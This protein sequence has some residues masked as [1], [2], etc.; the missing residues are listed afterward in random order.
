MKE[1]QIMTNGLSPQDA[2]CLIVCDC[3]ALISFNALEIRQ[4]NKKIVQCEVCKTDILITDSGFCG[5]TGL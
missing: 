4:I 1:L 2:N 3:G 5:A